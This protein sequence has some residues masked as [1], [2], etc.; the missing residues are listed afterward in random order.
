ML[1]QSFLSLG[2]ISILLL[3]GCTKTDLNSSL[4]ADA[5]DA[6]A[7]SFSYSSWNSDADLVWSD[8]AT[9]EPS[10]QSELVVPDLTQQMLDSGSIV[11]VYAKSAKPNVD[12][13]VQIMPAAYLDVNNNETNTYS[14]THVAGSIFVSHTRTVNGVFE[15]PNDLNETSFRYIIVNPAT[16]DPNGRAYTVDSFLYMSYGEVVDLLGIPE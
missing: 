14:A 13:P 7:Y 12:G 16:P 4:G 1:K 2:A 8:G 11:L 3:S 9:T 5:P 15:V 6:N 10:R